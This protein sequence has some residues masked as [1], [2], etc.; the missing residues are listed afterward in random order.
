MVCPTPDI[1][2]LIFD[3]VPHAG[4]QFALGHFRLG[5]S[6][7]GV[8]V[9]CELAN[10]HS[11]ESALDVNNTIGYRQRLKSCRATYTRIYRSAKRMDNK[12]N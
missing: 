12:A 9:T 1:R 2:Y 11:P 4:Q 8:K 6:S 5:R 7:R 10:Q 3:I